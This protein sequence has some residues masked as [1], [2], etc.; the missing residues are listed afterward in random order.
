[1]GCLLCA[2][3]VWDMEK[4]QIKAYLKGERYANKYYQAKYYK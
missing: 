1:M 2:S 4:Q 3:T